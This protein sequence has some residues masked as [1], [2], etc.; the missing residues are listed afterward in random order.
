M[1]L[2][3]EEAVRIAPVKAAEKEAPKE[4]SAEV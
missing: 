2:P 4:I 1:A 3:V